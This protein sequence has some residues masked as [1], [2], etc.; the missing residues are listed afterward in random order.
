MDTDTEFSSELELLYNPSNWTRRF[1]SSKDLLDHF[2]KVIRETTN[3]CRENIPCETGIPYGGKK[4]M[5]L[6]IFGAS[7]LPKDAPIFVHVHGGYWQMLDRQD[8]GYCVPALYAKG[9][10]VI[11]VGYSTAPGATLPEIIQEIKEA[12]NF[13]HHWCSQSR[14]P[15]S[16]HWSGHSA[17]AHL[18]AMTILLDHHEVSL[19]QD[20]PTTIW[21]LAGVYDLS[22][23]LQTSIND[24]LHMDKKTANYCSPQFWLDKVNST[25]PTR[26]DLKTFCLDKNCLQKSLAHTRI[27]SVCGG[28]ESP[29][30]IEQNA[31][32]VRTLQNLQI[33]RVEFILL[34]NLDHFDLVEKL[35]REE[36]SLTRLVIEEETNNDGY[37]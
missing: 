32:F 26:R 6:D 35:E 11:V 25:S 2:L 36:H 24:P 18:L 30:F 15:R 9:F 23:L 8:S 19:P 3:W 27:I 12:C 5:K 22:P 7:V 34:P 31:A 4:S 20:I 17:G 14:S 29:A 28:L 13:I 37:A 16:I 10:V 1:S 33:P 21:L